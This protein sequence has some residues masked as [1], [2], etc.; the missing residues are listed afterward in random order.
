MR[1]KIAIII[2][3]IPGSAK[4]TFADLFSSFEGCK[5]HSVDNLH[6]DSNGDFSWN[7]SESSSLY[8]KNLNNFSKDCE[9]GF[10]IVISDCVSYKHSHVEDYAEIAKKF[11]YRSYVVNSEP[12]S[13]SSSKKLNSHNVPDEK[14]KLFYRNWEPWPSSEKM[15]ELIFK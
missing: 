4:T 1:K 14:L 11:G 15:R 9:K 7:E 3:G 12:I 5:I 8:K 13:L 10:P 6:L 2:R